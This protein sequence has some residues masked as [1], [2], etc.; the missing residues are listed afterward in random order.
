MGTNSVSN[1]KQDKS[2]QGSNP[3][4][5]RKQDL[6]WN[7]VSEGVDSKGKK[8]TACN[9][10]GKQYVGI[11]SMKQHLAGLNQSKTACKEVSSEVRDSIVQSMKENK[12]KTKEK[13][14]VDLEMTD[15]EVK[16]GQSSQQ[17]CTSQSRKR[18]R[19]ATPGK[20][21]M[22]ES[23]SAKQHIDRI[24]RTKFS[25][26]GDENPLT[27][28]LHQAVK[29]L[30]AELYAK[31][32]HFLMELIQ[33][34]EDNEYPEGVDPS[35]E[36]V[37]TSDDITATG[38]PATLLIFNNEKGF[39]D[40]NIESICSVGRST[41]KGNRKRGYIGEKGTIRPQIQ[42][43]TFKRPLSLHM[44][45]LFQS[46]AGIGFKSVFLIT[47]QPYIFSNGYQIRFTEA[48]CSHCSLGYIVPEWVEQHPSLV[49]IQRIY[50]SGS[51]LPTTTIILPLKSDKVEPVKEQ[52]SNV[53]PEVLLFLS[54]IK[55]LSIRE[56]CQ[57]PNLSTVNSIG[58]IT[59]TNF[60]TRKSID[61]ESYTIHLSASETDTEKQ[62][63][64]Y[65]W[66][67]KFPVKQESRVE[68][69]TEVQDW[70]ITLAFPLGERLSRGNTSPGIY[71]FLPTEMV[72]NFPFIIQA[73]FI[74]ASSRE[75]IL[76]DDIW[77]QGILSCVPLAFVNAFTTLVKKTDAPISSLLSTFRFLPVT[78]SS[79]AKLNVV[80]D[81]IKE[82][83]CAEEIVPSVSHLGQKFFH[84]PC[85][86][87]R[88]IPA[89]WVI[90]EKARREGARLQNISSHGVY[91]LDSSFDKKE[92]DSVLNFLS[93][94]EVSNEWYSKCI[95][96]CDLVTSVSE[97]TYVEI[98][99]FIAQN[100]D[101]RFKNTNMV[102]V[103]LIKYHVQ[104]GATHLTSLEEFN[105]RTLCLVAEKNHSWLLDWNGEF[106]CMSDCVFLPH[107]TRKAL[108]ACSTNMD[109]IRNWLGEKITLMD[110]SVSLYAQ[111]LL[112]SLKKDNRLVVAYA[113]FLH[114][115]VTKGF[116][117]VDEAKK[118]CQDMPLVDNYGN[119][120]TS[121]FGVLVPAG[122]GKWVSLIT[123]SNPWRQDGY[124]ELWEEYMTSGVFAGVR[125][126]QRELLGFLKEYAKA[127]DVPEVAPPNA[128]LPALSGALQK[129]NVF[130]LLEWIRRHRNSLPSKF[131]D[132]VKGGSWLRTKMN[133]SYDYRPPS[134]SFYHTSSWGSVL[135]NGSVLVDVPLVDRSFYG[136]KIE[137][138]T[139]ELKTAGVMFEFSQACTFV[140]EHLMRLAGTS[141]L[142]RE[143]VFSILK[144]IRNLREK[145]LSPD[146]FITSIKG[147]SW[148]KTSSGDRSPVGAVL[149][150]EEWKAASLISEI[151]FVDGDAY[152]ES[153]ISGFKE[154]LKLL[155]VVVEFPNNHGLIVSHLKPEK[156]NYLTADAMILLLECMR[157]FTSQHLVDSLRSSQCLKTKGGYKSPAECFISDPDQTCFLT[158]FDDVFPLVD[159]SFYGS[160]ISSYKKELGQIGVVVQVEEAV[161]AFVR[162]FKQKAASSSLT[163]DNALSLLSF[164]KKLMGSDHKFPEEV[165]KSYTELQWLQTTLGGFR[166]P[167]ECILFCSEWEPLRLIANLPFID[168]TPKWYG[169][170]IHSYKKELR[171]LG[172]TVE[173]KQGMNHLVS[174]LS[175]PDESSSITP[176]SALSLLKCVTFLIEDGRKLTQE[177]LDKV[178]VRW[179]KTHAG[180]NSPKECLWF[181][182]S[183]ELE[184]CDGP[185]I[186][187]KYYGSK[188]MSFKRELIEVGV[189]DDP[190][191][192]RQLL[193]THVYTHSDSDAISRIYRFLSKTEW[194]PEKDS[195]SSSGRI[196]IPSD[197][198][199]ADVS[200]CVV[201]DEDKLFGSHLNVLENHYKSYDLLYFFSSAF[202]VRITP[203]VEDYCALW[204]DWER[205]KDR[206]S[207][208]ECCAFWSFLVRHGI[209]EDLL[210]ESFS[211]LPVKTTDSSNDE[212]GILLSSKSDVF[213]ADDL[214]LKDLFI[215][216]PV[217]VWYPTPS[218][219]RLSQ[220]KLM[221]LY[222]KIGVK[223]ISQCVETSEAKL[224]DRTKVKKQEKSLIGPG[225]VRLVLG[226]LS[227]PSLKIEAEERS[228]I[229]ESL[230]SLSV[231]QTPETISTDY[232]LKLPSKGEKLVAKAKKV[233]R[234]ERKEGV[235]YAEKIKKTCGKRKVLEYATC[236]AEVIAKGVMSG[237]EDLIEMLSEL[238][239]MAYL[240]EFDEDA[241]EFLMK[242]KNLEVYEEDE[243]LIS[244]AFSHK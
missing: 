176:S 211:R 220:T 94:R 167:E 107:E 75:I 111:C 226:F 244:D 228:R 16:D 136:K 5:N 188:L 194:K 179:L 34:A 1:T 25:I 119:V 21:K 161:K 100:W 13:I 33:N 128:A 43:L 114:H 208:H 210:S 200:S 148:L 224:T 238:V 205:T 38:A 241:L 86:V 139:E 180:Y 193:A 223:D 19:E 157:N 6:T 177:F 195:S 74:L 36:F 206:L 215:D 77:N 227:D 140:G 80:I 96:G 236:F 99:L 219:P 237:R 91:I 153:E 192:A 233:M 201:S 18:K 83:I 20:E 187:E 150:S 160:R 158:V 239:K 110:L 234:W 191:K 9:F 95:Q 7:Y 218:N 199:W 203:S 47:S 89:F 50:G 22:A 72:T 17:S 142:S 212:E 240:V 115:S 243:K 92:N 85:E 156:L 183:W 58:I 64:Y 82:R 3:R 67:Q 81:S 30:S 28:D 185:F 182:K 133:A 14:V 166:A 151:P 229:I 221:E 104:K 105:P 214:L 163:R 198:K 113:H 184:P 23:E 68:R 181:D 117:S 59:E 78:Q 8:V 162:A 196:W 174:S 149:F 204:K 32:V 189:V 79:Y 112:R 63:S 40:K 169:K 197:E 164:Y 4:S 93:L 159:D 66:R 62:C 29:N 42:N 44:C 143:N 134:Q 216:S 55:N 35:L 120:K 41:K 129:Q 242:S 125:S 144:F 116:L 49:D 24:R 73:D 225:L 76:L 126:K 69:R 97:S 172:V 102:K 106:R 90:L 10:C 88:L 109:V 231:L 131:L 171:S 65:M 27:E 232:T 108:N 54:K 53:H 230:V 202:N 15:Y 235:V 60:M 165:M 173:L 154:E 130:L 141:S 118:C 12:E 61:A 146:D 2:S 207:S 87:G 45:V 46:L 124:I 84:K 70:M 11:S 98:L 155:G 52:L 101:S 26:G 170:S 222:R 57:D 132:S 217:F 145:L 190:D 178:S 186:D 123:G 39:S 137:S 213:I 37:I 175:L 71:A 51:S 103:P 152:G 48:P 168:D 147:R 135:K 31:D 138:Y 122:A 56:H 209:S 127:G 121:T